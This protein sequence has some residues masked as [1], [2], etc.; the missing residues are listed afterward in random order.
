MCIFL[1][2][3]I[4]AKVE[5][6]SSKG[7]NMAAVS[8][9]VFLFYGITPKYFFGFSGYK[10]ASN[11]GINLGANVIVSDILEK[12]LLRFVHR[13]HSMEVIISHMMTFLTDETTKSPY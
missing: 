2:F 5:C 7:V 13:R 8:Q 3:F 10:T 4:L 9:Q 6:D 11:T 12:Q 1:F